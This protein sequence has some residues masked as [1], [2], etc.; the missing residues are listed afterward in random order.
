V[1]RVVAKD[2]EL[3]HRLREAIEAARNVET[4]AVDGVAVIRV[5]RAN[6]KELVAAIDAARAAG[7]GGIQLVWDGSDRARMERHVFAALEHAR[8]TQHAA[9]VVLADSEEPVPALC[10]LVHHRRHKS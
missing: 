3:A 10:V 1:I 6:R 2:P 8:A 4:P 9:P 7:A 5:T